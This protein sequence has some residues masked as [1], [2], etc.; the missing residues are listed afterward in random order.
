MDL[1][2]ILP[3]PDLSLAG[4]RI[5]EVLG[6]HKDKVYS[7][8]FASTGMARALKIFDQEKHGPGNPYE[9][10]FP[11]RAVHPNIV[12]VISVMGMSSYNPSLKGLG[13]VMPLAQNTLF[14]ILK[15]S[16]RT[17]RDTILQLLYD[18]LLGIKFMHDNRYIHLDIKPENV[19]LTDNIFLGR[20]VAQV[21]DFGFTRRVEDIHRGII[22][23]KQYITPAYRPPESYIKRDNYYNYTSKS[24]I[25][26]VGHLISLMLCRKY[27]YSGIDMSKMNDVKLT[28]DYVRDVFS[29]EAHRRKVIQDVCAGE[30]PHLLTLMLSIFDY[31]PSKRPTIEQVMESPLFN[32]VRPPTL[33][34]GDVKTNIDPH[35]IVQSTKQY[36]SIYRDMI[37]F[38]VVTAPTAHCR[39]F[40]MAADIYNRCRE[41]IGHTTSPLLDRVV[42]AVSL[43]ITSKCLY[44]YS[45]VVYH[46]FVGWAS[47]MGET[48]PES[49][50]DTIETNIYL[51]LNCEI[52]ANLLYMGASGKN[53]LIF[54]LNNYMLSD[55]GGKAPPSDGL[56]MS[57]LMSDLKNG[58]Q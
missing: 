16:V 30:S 12:S 42:A 34:K 3:P 27:M 47:G 55:K 19:F 29:V 31:D 56:K 13:V 6:S 53:E 17:S 35:S 45:L 52:D 11:A 33:P 24:D 40:F 8:T 4:L 26:T 50:F 25:W 28:G 15:S 14:G 48:I 39:M 54:V 20:P 10:D 23:M 9:I 32:S 43:W 18:T 5:N 36:A 7:V 38:M 57:T 22:M 44:H 51:A 49:Y 58:I 37:D 2:N 46:S 21:A 1:S 41:K